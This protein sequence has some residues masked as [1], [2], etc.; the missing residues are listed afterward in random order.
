MITIR[1]IERLFDAHQF[2]RLARELLENRP[3]CPRFD[4]GAPHPIESTPWARVVPVAAM[5]MIRLDELSQGSHPFYRRLLNV[6]LTSQE[7]DG[8]WGDPLTTSLC[9]RALLGNNGQG[10]S[11]HGGLAY[12]AA[13][14]KTEGI[15]PKEPIRRMPADAF[16][17]A[18][19]LHQ[20]G[21]FSAFRNAIRFEDAV[22]WFA[23]HA[24]D[25]DEETRRL[26]THAKTRCRIMTH[27]LNPTLWSPKRPA[28]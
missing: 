21:E 19:I 28:A 27:H 25:L 13:L 5:G 22:L 24:K 7:K 6:V 12:L 18:F 10:N 2:P 23:T 15:W 4:Q 3:E 26:W 8:G 20:L 17:S 16:I 9:L 14:Q 11:I 1:Q